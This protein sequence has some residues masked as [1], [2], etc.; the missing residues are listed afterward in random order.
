MSGSV[1][2]ILK[3]KLLILPSWLERASLRRIHNFSGCEGRTFQAEGTLCSRDKGGKD[4]Q[5]V[6]NLFSNSSRTNIDLKE[7]CL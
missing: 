7:V 2:Y 6:L 5:H 4:Y 1:K 3:R